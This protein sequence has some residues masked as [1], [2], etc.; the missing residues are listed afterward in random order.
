MLLGSG[1]ADV[2][3]TLKVNAPVDPFVPA[4]RYAGGGPPK[5]LLF[6]TSRSVPVPNAGQLGFVPAVNV[7]PPCPE[8]VVPTKDAGP[9]FADSIA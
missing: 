6:V 5:A 2:V 3:V 1:T 4:P 9:F 8:T 7:L